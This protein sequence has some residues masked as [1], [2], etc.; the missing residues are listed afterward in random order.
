MVG[1]EGSKLRPTESAEDLQLVHYRENEYYR[2]HTDYGTDSENNRYVTTLLYLN[3]VGQGGNTSFPNA[4]SQCKDENGYF[5][6]QPIK[7]S[8]LIFYNMLKDANVDPMSAHEAEPPING[9]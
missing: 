2:V 1:I 6:V 3:D 7:R 9:S 8:A 4:S 5:G